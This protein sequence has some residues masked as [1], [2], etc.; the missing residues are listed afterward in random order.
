MFIHGDKDTFVPFYMLDELYNACNTEKS[1]LVVKEASHA[2][3]EDENPD[4]YWSQID[5]FVNK[6]MQRRVELLFYKKGVKK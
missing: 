5:K 4:L 2:H 1:K 6:Y 3:A